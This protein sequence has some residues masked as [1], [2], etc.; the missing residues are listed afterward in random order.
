MFDLDKTHLVDRLL[1]SSE[2]SEGWR[3]AFYGAVVEASLC[4]KEEQVIVGPDGFPYF[5]LYSPERQKAFDS[6]CVAQILEH[7]TERGLG[8]A[9]NPDKPQPDWVFNY[10]SLWSLRSN[11]VFEMP[12]GVAQAAAEREIMVGQ[13]SD[14]FFPDWARVVLR[15]YLQRAGIA[16]PQ[17]LLLVDPSL[18]PPEALVFSVFPDDF[19][20]PAAYE[21][22]MHRLGWYLPNDHGIVGLAKA[23]PMRAHF[24]PL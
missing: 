12:I 19:P 7:C 21:E 2:R 22:V 3:A 11:G 10:G 14:D 1:A 15:G 20:T 5:A 23:S 16:E 4:T 6:C 8:I 24:Q 18:W 13:P 17:A 9:I